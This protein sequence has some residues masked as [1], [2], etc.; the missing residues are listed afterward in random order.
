MPWVWG[1]SLGPR[2]V[3]TLGMQD[4]GIAWVSEEPCKSL[5]FAYLFLWV[6]CDLE[7]CPA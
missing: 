3:P 4:D 1:P 5:C 7:L 6:T 2:G